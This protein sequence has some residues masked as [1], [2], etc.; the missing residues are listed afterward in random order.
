MPRVFISFVHED[1][2]VAEAVERLLGYELGLRGEVF[3]SGD[4]NQVHAGDQ[5]LRAVKEALTDAEIVVLMLSRRS[6]GRSWVNF[7]AGGAWL[8]GKPIIPC[9]YGRL[10]KNALPEP[11]SGFQAINLRDEAHYLLTSVHHHFA[12]SSKLPTSRMAREFK[13]AITPKDQTVG[14]PSGLKFYLILEGALD[15]FKDLP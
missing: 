2:D 6:I 1:L 10:D 9:C 12:L 7:E 4:Q 14:S 3:L 11:F 15:R 13:F 8:Q 5:W